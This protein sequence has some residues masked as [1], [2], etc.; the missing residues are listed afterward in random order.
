MIFISFNF[1]YS[2]SYTKGFLLVWWVYHWYVW[3]NMNMNWKYSRR[4]WNEIYL[5][6]IVFVVQFKSS[7]SV[8]DMIAIINWYIGVHQR[9]KMK[10]CLHVRMSKG[11][12][13][14][15]HHLLLW[16]CAQW[17]TKYQPEWILHQF[18]L[19]RIKWLICSWYDWYERDIRFI[20][21]NID[22]FKTLIIGNLEVLSF[23]T[24]FISMLTL[25]C[26]IFIHQSWNF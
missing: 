22:Y 16:T 5:F 20:I 25:L 4:I 18:K 21:K 8:E 6:N 3:R 26:V 2:L 17:L 12:N 10:C 24:D 14:H 23:F 15:H 9:Y 1:W 19:I 11:C 13:Y 7:F